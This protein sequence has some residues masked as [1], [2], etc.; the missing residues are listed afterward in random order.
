M[1]VRCPTNL[2]IVSDARDGPSP[3]GPSPNG[4]S[5]NGLGPNEPSPN[6][7]QAGPG[8]GLGTCRSRAGPARID[9]VAGR[10]QHSP[11]NNSCVP[12]ALSRNAHRWVSFLPRR[13]VVPDV[14]NA[15]WSRIPSIS[16]Q[17]AR[18]TNASVSATTTGDPSRSSSLGVNGGQLCQGTRGQHS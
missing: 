17:G 4:P 18:C 9:D 15:G 14:P 12:R 10:Q 7:L 5:P 11:A 16:T 3:N 8:S 13:A 6:G 2:W 1:G